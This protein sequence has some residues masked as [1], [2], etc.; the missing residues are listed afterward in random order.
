[1]TRWN[2]LFPLA[3]IV[4][5]A[6]NVIV[7]KLSAHTI[8]P[9]AITFYR[10]LLAVTLMSF[11]ALKPSWTNRA[12][13]IPQLHKL[14]FLGFLAMALFQS[15]SYEAAKT[16]T[17]TN[18]SIITALVPLMTMV[19][20]T[21]I[22]AE[23]PTG[24][25]VGG[26]IVSLMGVAYMITQGKPAVLLSDGPHL[27]DVLMILASVAY[28]V[29]GVLLKRWH[30][31]LASWQSLYIQ[32]IFAML[33]MLPLL[34]RLPSVDV[35][36]TQASLP[37][38]FYAGAIGSV[39]LPFLWMQGVKHLGPNRCGL[40]MNVLPLAT[41]L[42]A[43]TIFGETVHDYDALGGTITIFGVLLAQLYKRQIQ[44]TTSVAE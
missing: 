22:L 24:G 39:V 6:G 4:L 31:G 18:M 25:M 14:A 42:M 11:F 13:I 23:V 3:A 5:W 7:S 34:L 19:L 9:S 1:M 37:L 12:N 35:I 36:P 29:Y 40:F 17:A 30:V 32:A 28:S 8:H 10:L 27:G 33:F 16:T 21:I 20:S 2:F 43:I 41:A 44:R 15:L 26:G 38:I